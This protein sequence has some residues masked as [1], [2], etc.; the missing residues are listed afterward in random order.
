M[1][2]LGSKVVELHHISK[3]FDDKLLINKF[4]Y[5]FKRG[6]RIGIIGKNGTGKSTFVNMLTGGLSPDSGKVVIGETIKFGYYSQG[7]I[8]IKE[9]QKV[10]EVIKEYG[11][12]IPLAKGK[13]ISAGQLLERFLFDRNQT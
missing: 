2:R 4:D 8:S 7:G 1:E 10:I 9:G 5:V 12:Y 3:T 6:E 13:A 11:E